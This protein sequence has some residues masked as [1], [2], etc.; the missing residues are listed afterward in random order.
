[1]PSLK[2]IRTRI[3][4]IRSTRQITSAMKMVSASKLHRAQGGLHHLRKYASLLK[5][6]VDQVLPQVGGLKGHPLLAR[7]AVNE[8]LVVSVSSNKGLCGTYN[9]LLIKKTLNH[10]EYLQ[11]EGHGI[12]LLLVGK[13]T[14]GFFRKRVFPIHG[15]DHELIDRLSPELA[16][17]FAAGL[18]KDYEEGLFDRVDVVYNRFRNAVVQELVVEQVL[19]LQPPGQPGQQPGGSMGLPDAMAEEPFGY[20]L[21]PDPQQVCHALIPHHVSTAFYRI[22]L[23]AAASEHGARMTSMHKATDN[24][25]DL[26]H[27]LTLTYNKARQAQI[28]RELMDIVG[29]AEEIVRR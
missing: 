20:I 19:P 15:E 14:A 22:L 12:R 1:M 17:A 7:R 24:A 23:D 16:G 11:S 2:E 25:D 10:L 6:M 28:T 27:G 26:L 13:K 21:E 3:H 29:G 5:G 8:V 9:A 4:S 18:M